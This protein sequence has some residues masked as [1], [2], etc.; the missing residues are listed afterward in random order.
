[1]PAQ[2]TEYYILDLSLDNSL[3]RQLVGQRHAVFVISW[4]NPDEAM[5]DAGLDDYRRQGVM[6]ALDA[7]VAIVRGQRVQACGYWLGGT[8]LMIAAATMLE[9]SANWGVPASTPGSCA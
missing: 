9:A 7:I 2:I 4:R 5:R 1:M 6:A 3:V 8:I